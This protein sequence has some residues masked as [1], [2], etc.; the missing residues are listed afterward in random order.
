MMMKINRVFT[1][2]TSF[3]NDSAGCTSRSPDELG[4][5]RYTAVSSLLCGRTAHAFIV[6]GGWVGGQFPNWLT[7]CVFTSTPAGSQTELVLWSHVMLP[8]RPSWTRLSLPFSPRL[9]Y[10]F[11]LSEHR[12]LWGRGFTSVRESERGGRLRRRLPAVADDETRVWSEEELT[13]LNCCF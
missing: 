8:P 7:V 3:L 9:Y 13:R 4:V 12:R 5:R 2:S 6:A 1:S 11:P 10:D